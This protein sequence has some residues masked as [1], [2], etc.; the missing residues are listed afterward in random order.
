MKRFVIALLLLGFTTSMMAEIVVY[1]WRENFSGMEILDGDWERDRGSDRG[2]LIL[3]LVVHNDDREAGET[4]QVISSTLVEYDSGRWE[5]DPGTS[6]PISSAD[7]AGYLTGRVMRDNVR[8]LTGETLEVETGGDIVRNG[9]V[10]GT[11][12]G[13]CKS[14]V[15]LRQANQFNRKIEE[16]TTVGE[17]VEMVTESLERKRYEPGFARN[18]SERYRN[19]WVYGGPLVGVYMVYDNILSMRY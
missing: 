18:L 6:P 11:V 12:V 7:F 13:Y 4:V 19:Y 3:E 14:R 1:S 9:A 8:S 15:M 2:Y 5:D 17:V 16:D 10:N